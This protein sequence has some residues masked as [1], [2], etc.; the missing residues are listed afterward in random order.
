MHDRSNDSADT[1]P[2]DAV[3]EVLGDALGSGDRSRNGGTD[4]SRGD[5]GVVSGDEDT[6]FDLKACEIVAQ[7]FDN[8][9]GVGSRLYHVEGDVYALSQYRRSVAK[10]WSETLLTHGE[11]TVEPATLDS[12]VFEAAVDERGASPLTDE[13]L[14]HIRTVY[15]ET[16]TQAVWDAIERR[17]TNDGPVLQ[18]GLACVEDHTWRETLQPAFATELADEQVAAVSDALMDARPDLD[19]TWAQLYAV[20]VSKLAF[21]GADSGAA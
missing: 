3:A 13:Q 16:C 10:D 11:L 1:T 14:A 4:P 8:E 21:D 9:A 2:S 12:A 18:E 20:F 19:W 6:D 15:T 17:G 7:T 5:H